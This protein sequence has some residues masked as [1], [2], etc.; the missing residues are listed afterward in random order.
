MVSE[1]RI[2]GHDERSCA[3]TYRLKHRL[4]QLIGTSSAHWLQREA[5]RYGSR[6]SLFHHRE[7]S[8]VS[9]APEQ[10]NMSEAGNELRE[11]LELFP[12][13]LLGDDLRYSSYIS[14][15]LGKTRNEAHADWIA[16][17]DHHD[18]YSARSLLG[19]K[20]CWSTMR[21][22]DVHASP[23]EFGE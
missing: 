16:D 20:C 14:A 7:L 11:H 6:L 18:R 2:T 22:D 12:V 17:L 23:K 3:S 8:R 4:L 15:R 10:G 9:R 21:D 5:E 19:S 13:Y 1:E